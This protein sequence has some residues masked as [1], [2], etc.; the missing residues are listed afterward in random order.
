MLQLEA[1]L[2]E[3]VQFY[4]VEHIYFKL[5]VEQMLVVVL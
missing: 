1:K 5:A 2:E 3:K 4:G